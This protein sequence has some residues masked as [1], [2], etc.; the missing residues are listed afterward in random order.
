MGGERSLPIFLPPVLLGE[1]IARN[2]ILE[3]HPRW[4]V[5]AARGCMSVATTRGT[6]SPCALP[7]RKFL[8]LGNWGRS[9]L[10]FP[11]PS[12]WS[13]L[14]PLPSSPFSFPPTQLLPHQ[15]APKSGSGTEG[16]VHVCSTYLAFH[17]NYF[18]LDVPFVSSKGAQFMQRLLLTFSLFA[19]FKKIYCWRF[20][21][22][23]RSLLKLMT[24]PVG[25]RVAETWQRRLSEDGWPS[26]S[27]GQTKSVES[28]H[29]PCIFRLCKPTLSLKLKTS[30][31]RRAACTTKRASQ[32]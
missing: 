21:N 2:Q 16:P 27:Y 19:A 22:L 30:K 11:L 12:P 7:G 14:L 31:H 15:C 23:K 6:Q 20:Y 32:G 17:N 8:V 26:S 5:C 3:L 25:S 18:V 28:G 9:L 13:R 24:L 29:W 1:F 10:E 4:S